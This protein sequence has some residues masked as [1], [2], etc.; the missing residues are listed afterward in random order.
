ML[1]WV[2]SIGNVAMLAFGYAGEFGA[3]VLDKPG[4]LAIYQQ[5]IETGVLK[6]NGLLV[7]DNTMKRRLR[8]GELGP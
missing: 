2:I 1:F 5:L 3:T 7:V 6:V 4:Y 8:H